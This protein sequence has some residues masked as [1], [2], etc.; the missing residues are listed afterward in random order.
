MFDQFFTGNTV[1]FGVPALAGTAIFLVR[2]LLTLMGGDADS[3]GA[4]MDGGDFDLG[5]SGTY[6]G[7]DGVDD[8]GQAFAILSVHSV[9][10]FAMGFGWGGLGATLG[11]GWSPAAAMATGVGSGIGMVWLLALLLKQAKPLKKRPNSTL[12]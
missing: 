11:G 1:W 2:M 7:V 10:A 6:D 4:G 12:Y 9:A 3:D 5:D 8:S